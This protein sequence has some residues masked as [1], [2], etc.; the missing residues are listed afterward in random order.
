M[1]RPGKLR[2]QPYVL[3]RLLPCPGTYRMIVTINLVD[4][5]EAKHRR[6]EHTFSIAASAPSLDNS[7]SGDGGPQRKKRLK[8]TSNQTEEIT[9]TTQ[10]VN[11][12]L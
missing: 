11:F 8:M 5:I 7:S 9:V 3:T 2:T 1:L 12:E 4:A 6:I 10:E